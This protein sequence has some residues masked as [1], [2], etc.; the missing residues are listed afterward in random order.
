MLVNSRGVV[1]APVVPVELVEL[2]QGAREVL[3]V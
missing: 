1:V 3:V 2:A